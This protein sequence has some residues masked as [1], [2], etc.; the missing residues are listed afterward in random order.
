MKQRQAEPGHQTP[1]WTLWLNLESAALWQ[2]VSLSMDEEPVF[3]NVPTDE[4]EHHRRLALLRTHA[5]RRSKLLSWPIGYHFEDRDSIHQVITI[6]SF[7]NWAAAQGWSVPEEMSPVQRRFAHSAPS[8]GSHAQP[9]MPGG[10][11]SQLERQ[12]KRYNMCVDA[13]LEMPS[14]DYAHL[15]RG[16][17]AVAK[18]EGITRQA[19][20]EDVKAHIRRLKGG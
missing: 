20:A 15:P 18:R 17:G 14:D 19:F 2:L 12:E 4:A 9:R 3:S 1:D 11:E 10:A 8:K 7:R 5:A 13:G 6:E 16:V